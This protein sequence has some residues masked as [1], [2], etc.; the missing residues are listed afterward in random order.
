MLTIRRLMFLGTKEGSVIS[1][2]MD[3]IY[4]AGYEEAVVRGNYK[5]YCAAG[6]MR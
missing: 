4:R 5:I 1:E 2:Y 6:F 3:I